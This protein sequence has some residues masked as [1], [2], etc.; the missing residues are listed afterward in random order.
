LYVVN[1]DL[2][3]LTN[4]LNEIAID[5]SITIYYENVS[6]NPVVN[7]GS[8]TA[9]QLLD[10]M[11]FP[12]ADGNPGGYMHWVNV[13]PVPPRQA[14]YGNITGN[15]NGANGKLQLMVSSA[16]GPTN[17]IIQA[18]VD[19]KN[20]VPIYTNSGPFGIYT[21]PDAGSYSHRF[22]RTVPGH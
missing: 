10:G 8:Q 4:Y 6:L 21:D 1:L 7:T 3:Q 20:W 5:P 11:R 16:A 19:L 22:Y 14:S 15:Y 13:G 12:D 17:F 18:S 2:T 9:N